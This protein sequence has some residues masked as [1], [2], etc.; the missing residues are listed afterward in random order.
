MEKIS[1][2]SVMV[3]VKLRFSGRGGLSQRFPN[4]SERDPN[5]SL[6]NISRPKPQ[7]AYFNMKNVLILARFVF[8]VSNLLFLKYIR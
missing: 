2:E 4:F 3:L 7:T 8:I 6:V 1:A 5:L